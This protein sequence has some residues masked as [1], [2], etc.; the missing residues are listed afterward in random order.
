MTT[1]ETRPTTQPAT[2]T[3]SP[4]GRYL[5][6]CRCRGTTPTARPHYELEQLHRAAVQRALRNGWDS[7]AQRLRALG[8]GR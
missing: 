1:T 7:T 8:G 6:A 2:P 3:D 4:C 5:L